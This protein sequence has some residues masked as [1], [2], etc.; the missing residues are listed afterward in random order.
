MVELLLFQWNFLL[1]G[2]CS[3]FE[4]C[5]D[6]LSWGKRFKTSMDNLVKLIRDSQLLN[7]DYFNTASILQC[8]YCSGEKISV[9]FPVITVN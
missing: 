4:V 3:T 5:A 6:T 9:L 1:Y 8:V 7:Y 2:G